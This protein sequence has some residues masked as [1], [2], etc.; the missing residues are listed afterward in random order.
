MTSLRDAHV[1]ITGGSEGIGLALAEAAAGRGATVSLI[2]RRAEP[3]AVAAAA[4]VVA[5]IAAASAT[6]AAAVVAVVVIGGSGP[7][8]TLTSGH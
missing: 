1:I 4:P 8:V 2:A 6:V 7:A 3:L 5:T